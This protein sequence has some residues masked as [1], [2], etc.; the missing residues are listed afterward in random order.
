MSDYKEEVYINISEKPLDIGGIIPENVEYD[1]TPKKGYT[2]NIETDLYYGEFDI[3]CKG[4]N[5]TNYNSVDA[6]IEVGDY[7]MTIKIPES[8]NYYTGEISFDFSIVKKDT[9]IAVL[10]AYNLNNE[11]SKQFTYGNII[12]IKAPVNSINKSEKSSV[13]KFAEPSERQMAL[14]IKDKQIPEAVSTNSDVFYNMI[15]DTANE[16]MLIGQNMWGIIIPKTVQE[17]SLSF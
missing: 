2:G 8:A 15:L 14:Y 10:K 7:T 13:D 3:L 12:S 5:D 16:N 6:P 4:R 1:G 9:S 11:E 17:A